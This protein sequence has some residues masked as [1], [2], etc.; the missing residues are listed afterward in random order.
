ML[1]FFRSSLDSLDPAVADLI[2]Y[3]ARDRA[4]N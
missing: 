4:E 1:S 2:Q 3:E